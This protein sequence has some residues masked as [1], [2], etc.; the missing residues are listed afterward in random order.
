MSITFSISHRHK[1]AGLDNR[2]LA[3]THDTDSEPR[4]GFRKYQSGA[5]SDNR[6]RGRG[7]ELS[8]EKTK[9]LI[10]DGARGPIWL[11]THEQA[12]HGFGRLRTIF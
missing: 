10:A 9:M 4:H 7:V 5:V 3:I 1:N 2:K 8:H 6:C 12:G 11:T